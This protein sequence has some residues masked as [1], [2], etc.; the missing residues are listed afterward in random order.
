MEPK[1]GGKKQPY[2]RQVDSTLSIRIEDPGAEGLILP[3][4][5][6]YGDLKKKLSHYSVASSSDPAGINFDVFREHMVGVNE[7]KAEDFSFDVAFT[8]GGSIFLVSGLGP[9]EAGEKLKRLNK[10]LF[11]N[12]TSL[13]FETFPP[14]F[15]Y[16]ISSKELNALETICGNTAENVRQKFAGAQVSEKA[17]DFDIE[18][19]VADITEVSG[20]FDRDDNFLITIGA[21]DAAYTLYVNP[22]NVRD[23]ESVVCRFTNNGD[24]FVLTRSELIF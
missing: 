9:A 19:F 12:C 8:E 1:Q 17:A 10:S 20:M 3:K 18:A 15:L 2:V 14:L 5:K 16:R 21:K 24:N 22:A 7:L 4:T 23:G 13:V 6:R 11:E